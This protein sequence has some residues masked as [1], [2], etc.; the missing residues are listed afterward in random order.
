MLQLANLGSLK[1]KKQRLASLLSQSMFLQ[2]NGMFWHTAYPL[3]INQQDI[4]LQYGPVNAAWIYQI[5]AGAISK[6]GMTNYN[7][8][9]ILLSRIQIDRGKHS[10]GETVN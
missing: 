10:K 2:H 4:T 3:A 9:Q 8:Q 7:K 1:A 5:L 6:M